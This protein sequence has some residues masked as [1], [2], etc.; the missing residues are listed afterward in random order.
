MNIVFD[1]NSSIG[2]TGKPIQGNQEDFSLTVI[3]RDEVIVAGGVEQQ[4][5]QDAVIE[6]ESGATIDHEADIEVH[7]GFDVNTENIE[8]WSSDESV[9]TVA[10]G[11][12][13]RVSDGTAVVY[14]KING[15]TRQVPVTVFREA[16]ATTVRL[17]GY[18]EGSFAKHCSEQIQDRL[19]IA[20]S[21]TGKKLLT[22]Y[23]LT[24]DTYVRNAASWLAG[25]DVTSI[26]VATKPA[27]RANFWRYQGGLAIAKDCIAYCN[28][29]GGPT[30]YPA[31]GRLKGGQV[32]YL[33][34]DGTVVVRDIVD[35][36]RIGT[37]DL[38]VAKLDADLPETVG[39]AK[40]LPSNWVDYLPV[41]DW[42][43]PAFGI[44]QISPSANKLASP[45]MLRRRSGLSMFSPD[46]PGDL[47]DWYENAV[48]YDSGHPAFL[49]VNDELVW[50]TVWTTG[51]A[52]GG[53]SVVQNIDAINAA[54][55]AMGSGY[56][57]TT[58]DLSGF[59]NYGD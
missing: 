16:P 29:W 9:L 28:H 3:P 17:V 27:P 31:D 52:G 26:P 14:A 59:E 42:M 1:P 20:D 25:V 22:T 47:A 56:Q 34:S 7:A 38:V 30:G 18:A 24:T 13:T 21:S 4:T 48:L 43:V 23:N 49:L 8:W 11:K 51:G 54:M 37:T 45:R 44:V 5:V 36:S 50:L 6:T 12:V 39:I 53:S 19:A 2:L 35:D 15:L 40:V 33:G 46:V 41:N 32:K 57:L 55:T 10:D 58:A